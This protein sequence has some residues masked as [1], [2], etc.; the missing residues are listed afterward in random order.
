MGLRDRDYYREGATGSALESVVLRLIVLNG[1]VFLAEV[2]LDGQAL[3]QALAVRGDTLWRPW[4]WYRLLTA[5]FV[6]DWR[7]V[8]HILFNMLGLYF[9]GTPLEDRYG[10]REFLRFYLSAVVLGFAWWAVAQAV[11]L[12]RLPL[13][14]LAARGLARNTLCYGASGAVT[15]VTLLF[16]LLYP[17]ATVLAHLIFPM[18]A[19]LL[20]ALLI[21]TNLIGSTQSDVGGSRVA[22]NVHL[23]GAAFAGAYWYFGW[24]LGRWL[25]FQWLADLGLRCRSWLGRRMHLRVHEPLSDEDDE[26]MEAEADR[27]LEK[28]AQQGLGSLTPQ[29][30]RFL[31]SYSRRMRS[32]LR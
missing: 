10:P 14:P 3:A 32:R 15:A 4:E 24:H 28:V 13:E 7:A 22:Y 27:L 17:R 12:S 26:A 29:E 23:A 5:G 11:W 21:V 30:R 16:C 19:W 8:N 1:L 18:P 6:H 9:F 2:L 20:G 25:Q 31:E